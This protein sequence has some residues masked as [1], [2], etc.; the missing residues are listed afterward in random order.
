LQPWRQD[1]PCAAKAAAVASAPGGSG[2]IQVVAV[3]L[4]ALNP[5]VEEGESLE[6]LFYRLNVVWLEGEK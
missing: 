6:S 2:R 4:D 5:L 3:V 1:R